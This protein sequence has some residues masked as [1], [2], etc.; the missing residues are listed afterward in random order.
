MIADTKT[1]QQV[2]TTGRKIHPERQIS[3][4][5]MSG[6]QVRRKSTHRNPG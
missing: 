6:K 4:K 5:H 2:L 3:F 1:Y